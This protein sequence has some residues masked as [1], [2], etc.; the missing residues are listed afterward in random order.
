MSFKNGAKTRQELDELIDSL[1]AAV[2]AV[3]GVR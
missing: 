3:A 1:V 2:T